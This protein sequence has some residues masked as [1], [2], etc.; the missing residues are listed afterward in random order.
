MLIC[1]AKQIKLHCSRRSH[2]A[3]Q[4]DKIQ[5]SAGTAAGGIKER[6]QLIAFPRKHTHFF[7]S[8]PWHNCWLVTCYEHHNPYR[9]YRRQMRKTKPAVPHWK[10]C[11]C[12]SSQIVPAV[13]TR[14]QKTN[15][16]K[17]KR[18]K[19]S[20]ARVDD[21]RTLKSRIKPFSIPHKKSYH[22]HLLARCHRKETCLW[23]HVLR[24][25]GRVMVYCR[26]LP[27]IC[28]APPSYMWGNMRAE[29]GIWGGR[30]KESVIIVL[31]IYRSIHLSERDP[32]ILC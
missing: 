14:Q 21:M 12:H 8:T 5:Y 7:P 25:A 6:C 1:K 24:W 19:W 22:C 11:L 17:R 27:R 30:L 26:R 23:Y 31:W 2:S 15:R 32:D 18:T 4:H 20:K 29:R 3:Q 9:S 13:A 28:M 16:Q 10:A